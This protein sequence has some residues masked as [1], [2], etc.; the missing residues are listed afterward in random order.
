MTDGIKANIKT[1]CDLRVF[2]DNVRIDKDYK[3]YIYIYA[4]VCVCVEKKDGINLNWQD[5][6]I[7]YYM[8]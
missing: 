3:I 2:R 5:C 7:L 8:D 4:C 6:D 1:P